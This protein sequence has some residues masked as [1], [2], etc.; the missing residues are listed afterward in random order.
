MTSEVTQTAHGTQEP[1]PKGDG[2]RYPTGSSVGRYVIRRELGRGG[3][4]VVLEAYDPQLDR[5]VALKLLIAGRDA[6]D[7]QLRRFMREA[8]SASSLRHAN[9][10]PVHDLGEV[11]GRAY[12]AMDRIEGRSLGEI[13]EKE[14]KL[15]P[16]RAFEIAL[17]VA[18]G[19]EHAH[20]N[21]IVH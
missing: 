18:R 15:P 1:Q 7:D 17:D 13:L 16:R 5:V 2:L 20:A 6:S 14:G 9:I 3:V 10:V 11:D 21:G 12:F 4:G 19:L 8:R